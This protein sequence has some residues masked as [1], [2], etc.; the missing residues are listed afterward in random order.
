M[1]PVVIGNLK[2]VSGDYSGGMYYV[3]A[4]LFLS[5]VVILIA[6]PKKAVL[7]QRLATQL[8]TEIT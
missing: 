7:S 8:S 4:T 5:A 6:A 1:G 3:A 2:A